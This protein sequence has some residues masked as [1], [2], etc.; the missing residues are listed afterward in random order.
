MD[1]G[2]QGGLMKRV[3]EVFKDEAGEWRWRMIS[4]RG[5]L[6]NEIVATSGEGYKNRKHAIEMAESLFPEYTI[7][8]AS[9][10]REED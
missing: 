1:N 8:L 5:N 9:A 3:L 2:L 7:V 10:T 6:P 4:V